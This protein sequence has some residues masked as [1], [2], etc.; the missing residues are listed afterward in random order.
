M[1]HLFDLAFQLFYPLV[2]LILRNSIR[3]HTSANRQ[4][5]AAYG[6]IR[7]D[8]SGYDSIRQHMSAY[9]DLALELLS[10]CPS[11]RRAGS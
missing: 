7:Q 9:V 2:L 3:Q 4:Q 1:L 11:H 5:T 10:A 6:R 8:T